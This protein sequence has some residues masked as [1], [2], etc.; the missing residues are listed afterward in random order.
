M[1]A[2]PYR[3]QVAEGADLDPAGRGLRGISRRVFLQVGAASGVALTLTRLAAAKEPGFDARETLPGRS[4]WNPAATAAGRIDGVAK[5]TR[6]NM[7]G[8][9][10]GCGAAQC[11]WP[12]PESARPNPDH[13]LLRSFLW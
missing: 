10:F 6:A 4:Q 3:S 11:L 9:K 13:S 1:A 2:A 5:V 8:T 12:K 7:T